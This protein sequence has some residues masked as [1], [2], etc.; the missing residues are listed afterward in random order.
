MKLIGR[1]NNEEWELHRT[2]LAEIERLRRSGDFLGIPVLYA[3]RG[4]IYELWPSP[5]DGWTFRVE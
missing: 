3:F 2:S 4:D 5:V 1:L